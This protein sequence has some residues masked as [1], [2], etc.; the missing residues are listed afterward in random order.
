MRLAMISALMAGDQRVLIG[1]PARFT[2]PVHPGMAAAHWDGSTN[3]MVPPE[4]EFRR[5]ARALA[6]SRVR[7]MTSWLAA[8]SLATRRVPTSRWRRRWRRASSPGW[9]G[10]GARGGG[11]DGARGIAAAS[12][13]GASCARRGFGRSGERDRRAGRVA[14]RAPERQ[15]RRSDGGAPGERRGTA[16]RARAVR[17]RDASD[18]ARTGAERVRDRRRHRRGRVTRVR[19]PVGRRSRRCAPATTA[20]RDRDNADLDAAKNNARRPV[21]GWRAARL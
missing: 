14:E 6:T 8:R 20:R 13:G 21:S 4:K 17:R 1:S 7:M 11:D 3:V 5:A 15:R 16:D 18:G 10:R 12:G 9:G 19:A 2:T